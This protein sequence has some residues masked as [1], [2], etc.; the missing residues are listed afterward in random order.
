MLC[1]CLEMHQPLYAAD[2]E[3][4][5]DK[6][7]YVEINVSD[8]N[9]ES[10][11]LP[12]SGLIYNDAYDHQKFLS[13]PIAK[14]KAIGK[15]AIPILPY[16]IIP[17]LYLGYKYYSSTTCD[18]DAEEECDLDNEFSISNIGRT[19]FDILGGSYLTAGLFSEKIQTVFTN[20]KNKLLPASLQSGN[21]AK[22]LKYQK[23]MDERFAEGKIT[24]KTKNIFYSFLKQY[25]ELLKRTDE[26][27]ED[28]KFCFSKLKEIYK[29][30]SNVKVLDYTIIKPRLEK[31]L[32]TYPEEIQDKAREIVQKIVLSSH[33]LK[34][35]KIIICFYGSP[36]TGKTHLA[37][38]LAEILELSMTY[39]KPSSSGAEK[40]I[41]QNIDTDDHEIMLDLFSHKENNHLN[42][43][44]F[45]DEFDCCLDKDNK[46]HFAF[47]DFFTN[48]C[49]KNQLYYKSAKIYNLD[50]DMSSAIIIMACNNLPKDAAIFS[51]IPVIEFKNVPIEKQ[52]PIAFNTFKEGL[53]NY[54]LPEE[55]KEENEKVLQ[56]IV[57]KNTFPG[58]RVLK[59]IV[60]QY[61]LHHAKLAYLPDENFNPFNVDIAYKDY[62]RN[63]HTK[64]D[65]PENNKY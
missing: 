29:L 31:L 44:L 61:V 59:D 16:I 13:K 54:R 17:S 55:I 52:L 11:F 56:E 15:K 19:T 26:D 53:K 6:K 36:G 4:K 57:N 48:V 3:D 65:E 45:I 9:L 49:E 46:H 14:A 18:P 20:L 35:K 43:I 40:M 41:A 5:D 50:I 10:E 25:K 24:E 1:F 12:P 27:N 58:V 23:K 39:F 37:Q 2:D 62:E 32:E 8:L 21:Y 51:R 60:D 7:N 22:I 28:A 63:E 38:K 33:S 30:P 64:K 34:P 47:R 42:N